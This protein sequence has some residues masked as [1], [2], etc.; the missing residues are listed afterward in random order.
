MDKYDYCEWQR[1]MVSTVAGDEQCAGDKKQ[2][3]T[4]VVR[5]FGGDPKYEYAQMC[6]KHL[7]LFF[8][9]YGGT[10]A[11]WDSKFVPSHKCNDPQCATVAV[12]TEG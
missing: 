10:Q 11:E 3:L 2:L 8:K 5:R 1:F 4:G 12:V 9:L 7:R 6:D